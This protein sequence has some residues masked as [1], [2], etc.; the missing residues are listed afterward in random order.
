MSSRVTPSDDPRQIYWGRTFSLQINVSD[1]ISDTSGLPRRMKRQLELAH[2][3]PDYDDSTDI[4]SPEHVFSPTLSKPPFKKRML[5]PPFDL[6]TYAIVRNWLSLCGGSDFAIQRFLELPDKRIADLNPYSSRFRITLIC[7]KRR[8][9]TISEKE[10]RPPCAW[11]DAEFIQKESPTE[12][13]RLVFFQDNARR[14]SHLIQVYSKS[15]R[16]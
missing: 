16:P 6:Q 13:L 8:P 10:N 11:F 15:V 7:V 9:I 14:F 4:F 3:F 2:I 1:R 12:I 5:E